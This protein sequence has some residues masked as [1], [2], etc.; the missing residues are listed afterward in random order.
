MVNRLMKTMAKYAARTYDK[1]LICLISNFLITDTIWLNGFSQVY[2][3]TEP[4]III[5]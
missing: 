1:N 3:F 4:R 5:S 2:I